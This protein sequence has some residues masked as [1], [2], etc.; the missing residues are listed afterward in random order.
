MVV[1]MKGKKSPMLL[2]Q[3]AKGRK[4][5]ARAL[6]RKALAIAQKSGSNK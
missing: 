2:A 4:M 6:R 1:G 3:Q 5:S